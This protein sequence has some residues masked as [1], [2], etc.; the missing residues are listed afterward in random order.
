MNPQNGG[1]RFPTLSGG[2]GQPAALVAVDTASCEIG[3]QGQEGEDG[4]AEGSEGE[5]D[6][7]E[8]E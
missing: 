3:D 7:G 8:Q 1:E 2:P 6:P 5:P 4:T